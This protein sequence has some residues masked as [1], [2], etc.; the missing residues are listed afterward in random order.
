MGEQEST[1][2]AI[3]R[4]EE[5][6]RNLD[7]RMGTLEKLTGTVSSLGIPMVSDRASALLKLSI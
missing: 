7:R 4:M 2:V 1:S 5:Q 3:A 6:I